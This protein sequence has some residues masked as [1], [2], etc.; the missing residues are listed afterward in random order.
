MKNAS[1]QLLS[2]LRTIWLGPYWTDLVKTRTT[3]MPPMV[4][5]R[6]HEMSDVCNCILMNPF[7]YVSSV[8][9]QTC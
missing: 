1:G 2:S 4:L 3:G 7:Y 5:G 8:D 9:A 6:H